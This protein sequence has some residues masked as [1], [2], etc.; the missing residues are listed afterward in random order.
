MVDEATMA[1][2][3]KRARTNEIE[4]LKAAAKSG[5]DVGGLVVPKVGS[6]PAR[7]AP[8]EGAPA[9]LNPGGETPGEQIGKVA[10]GADDAVRQVANAAT[11]GTADRMIAA[12]TGEPL[13]KELG[14]TKDA[15]ERLG[16]TAS[17]VADTAGGVL[18]ALALPGS[19]FATLPQ[20]GA[21]MGALSVANDVG[22]AIGQDKPLASLPDL[23][24]DAGVSAV[25]GM[26]GKYAGDRLGNLWAKTMTE[27][28]TTDAN[29]YKDA[30][31]NLE[32]VKGVIDS[33]SNQMNTSG[34]TVRSSYINKIADDLER[35][36]KN[37]P[38][39]RTNSRPAAESA[40]AT[41]RRY[42]ADGA[43]FSLKELNEMR[44]IIRDSVLDT[45]GSI[46]GGIR[47]E[48]ASLVRAMDRRI[49]GTIANL[50]ST[51]SAVGNGNVKMGVEGWKKMNEQVPK[52]YKAAMI[53]DVLDRA[54]VNAKASGIPFDRALQ[55]AFKSL[56][57]SKMGRAEFKGE[58]REWIRSMA[59]GSATTQMLNR[60]DRKYGH[61]LFSQIYNTLNTLP[62][63]GT[64]KIAA[65]S[66]RDLMD[67]ITPEIP[68]A[69]PSMQAGRLGAVMSDQAGQQGM[70][71]L[72]QNNAFSLGNA[73]P[74]PRQ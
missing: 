25:T 36:L 71:Q 50:E 34:V 72:R 74:P 20:T 42:A 63:S 27:G 70:D 67:R 13:E 31:K 1:Q 52:Q 54:D 59:E 73:M 48:D 2:I 6:T 17:K 3:R 62:R 64:S 9:T 18:Q 29:L 23:A 55:Q 4:A 10:Q 14:K 68:I 30:R 11:F 35:D 41:I 21:T 66:A 46:A 15:R 53:A 12:A 69:R 8:A 5:S 26:V 28:K 57:L 40:L 51:P 19:S 24:L 32:K 16:P 43:D 60:L 61:G 33:A 65:E 58:E 45:T 38:S 7:G 37:R 44:Q 39:F 49:G 47:Y 22:E 56:Y